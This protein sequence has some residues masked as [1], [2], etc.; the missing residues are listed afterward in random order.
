MQKQFCKR[1]RKQKDH[2]KMDLRNYDDWIEV[3]EDGIKR[4]GRE[5][6]HSPPSR[7]EVKNTWNFASTPQFFFIAWCL[8]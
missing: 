3:A 7:F 1:M 4:P 8:I 6:D 2:I 5:A